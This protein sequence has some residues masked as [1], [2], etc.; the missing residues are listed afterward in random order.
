MTRYAYKL[1]SGLT[2]L[3]RSR[4]HHIG[5]VG[6]PARSSFVPSPSGWR[7][8]ELRG[9]VFR[10]ACDSL[11]SSVCNLRRLASASPSME[12]P[13]GVTIVRPWTPGENPHRSRAEPG[14]AELEGHQFHTVH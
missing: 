8:V 10:V 6:W 7:C 14:R 9:P 5:H 3:P 1:A 12:G 2:R 13:R 4:G 11:L